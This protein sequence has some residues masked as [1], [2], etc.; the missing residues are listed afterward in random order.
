MEIKDRIKEAIRAWLFPN[1]VEREVC[2][3]PDIISSGIPGLSAWALQ[4]H[5]EGKIKL[6][7]VEFPNA[8][9]TPDLA[10]EM[11]ALM[12]A[13]KYAELKEW[14]FLQLKKQEKAEAMRIVTT[15]HLR[16]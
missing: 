1:L 13:E 9:S 12:V 3:S 8:I 4:W 2:I 11:R 14:W 16:G 10:N 5:K 6:E 15:D 7:E